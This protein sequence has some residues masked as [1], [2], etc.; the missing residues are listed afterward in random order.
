[1]KL[2]DKILVI[3]GWLEDENNELFVETTDE[4]VDK[5]AFAFAAAADALK[6]VAE[7]IKE[8]GQVEPSITPE[9]LEELAAV[10][11]SFDESGDELL[12]KQASVLD[13]LLLTLAAPKGYAFNFK[14]AEDDKLESLKKK[15]KA[16]KEEQDKNIGA[17]EAVEAIKNSPVA[18]EY[19]MLEAPL[20]TRTCIDHP[21]AQLAHIG[22][23]SWQCSL[24]HKI[25]NYSTGFT[26]LRG[27]KV[28]GGSVSEQTPSHNEVGGQ[29]FDNR[30]SR[31]GISRE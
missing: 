4:N 17:K 6:E 18:K 7:E 27:D 16:V 15:Y 3:A 30:E 29:V 21:G 12:Q 2:S 10:A 20:S 14:K 22:D 9:K 13:E 11:A 23:D 31:L 28:P 24:D 8:Q 1:M 26:T 5:V 25:Y 19:R